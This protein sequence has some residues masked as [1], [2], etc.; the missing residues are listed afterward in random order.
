LLVELDLAVR[1][2]NLWAVAGRQAAR[3]ETI[4]LSRQR[5]GGDGI[6]EW[7]LRPRIDRV[8]MLIR[9]AARL[10]E[11]VVCER[12]FAARHMR[13]QSFEKGAPGLMG[14]ESKIEEIVQI[15]AALRHAKSDRV[16]DKAR[17][18][19]PIASGIGIFIPQ[20]RDDVA[21]RSK[22]ETHDFRVLCRVDE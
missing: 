1:L 9:G 13:H 22:T 12:L 15:T 11:S 3:H 14:V 10:A 17:K 16:V 8:R 7:E 5:I 6:S 2:D 20:E 4:P 18:H 19:I 21:C